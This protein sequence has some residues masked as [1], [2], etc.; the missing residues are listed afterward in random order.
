MLRKSS[1]AACKKPEKYFLLENILGTRNEDKKQKKIYDEINADL[2]EWGKV[3]REKY[4]GPLIVEWG[5]EANN[6]TFHWNPACR[7]DRDKGAYVAMFRKAFRH[8]V[9]TV[10]G[11]E[12][13]KS[14]L[15]WVF[16]VTAEGD[17]VPSESGNEWNRMA[18]YYPD[19]TKEDPVDVVDWLGV[20]VYGADNLQTGECETFAEQLEKAMGSKDGKGED[21][22]L[23]ALTNRSRERRKP[24]FILEFGTALNY[25][26]AGTKIAQC[27]PETWIGQAF[28]E[29]FRR[30]AKGEIAGF[31]WW[32]ER[33]EGGGHKM[34]EMRFDHLQAPSIN[35]EAI[36]KAYNSSLNDAH[37]THA[38]SGC[39]ML[40]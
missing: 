29:I 19:G 34:L 39:G 15:T 10:T 37:V 13:E 2:R 16:H 14:N 30:A 18:D 25:D 8:I 35:R 7:R 9:R 17:P 31:S 38:T 5:T 1:D 27:A 26:Q 32:N 36:L 24:V 20:S 40:R 23:L 28:V 6:L 22:R 11:P 12:P 21:E 4:R 33:F 3:A